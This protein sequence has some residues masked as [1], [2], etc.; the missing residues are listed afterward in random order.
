MGTITER[1]AVDL[2]QAIRALVAD[3]FE[4]ARTS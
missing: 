2:A 4:L 3:R 1:S